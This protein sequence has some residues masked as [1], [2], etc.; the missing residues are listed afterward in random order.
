MVFFGI[1]VPFLMSDYPHVFLLQKSSTS[2]R[3]G[4]IHNPAVKAGDNRP[5]LL[6]IAR[7]VEAVLASK[8]HVTPSMLA[9]ME[10]L[11]NEENDFNLLSQD[12]KAME[13]LLAK[14]SV[15]YFFTWIYMKR[16]LVFFLFFCVCFCC[17]F[18]F[19]NKEVRNV[20]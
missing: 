16:C 1:T 7:T 4:L 10:T 8:P 2:T 6:Q 20:I 18:N 9:A 15:R 19:V 14:V 13:D 11:M 5:E 3:V 17:Y 12:S